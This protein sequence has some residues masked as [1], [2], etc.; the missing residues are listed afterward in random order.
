MV[1][2]ISAPFNPKEFEDI[3][4]SE[5]SIPNI[6]RAATAVN[7]LV[8]EFL[9]GGHR[10]VV[11]STYPDSG[12]M[13]Y[14]QGGNLEVYLVSRFIFLPKREIYSRI[15]VWKRIERIIRLR[16]NELDVLHAHWTYDYAM[17]AQKYSHILPVFCTVRDWCPYQLVIHKNIGSRLYWMVSYYVFKKVMQNSNL[18]LIANSYYTFKMVSDYCINRHIEIIQNP[19]KKDFIL[20]ERISEPLKPTFISIS[21]YIDIRKNIY[22]LLLA[23]KLYKERRPDA[24]LLLVGNDFNYQNENIRTWEK[25]G[26]LSNVKLLGWVNHEDLKSLLDRATALIHPSL[27]ETFGN[28]LLEGMA[29][30]LPVIGGYKSGAV[31]DVLGHGKYGLL[32]D[33]TDPMAIY[34]AMCQIENVEETGKMV[35]L[36]TNYIKETYTSEIIAQKHLDLY[37]SKIKAV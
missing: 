29:R 10:V 33:V 20:S 28:I 24:C 27:E 30:C 9:L 15:Y 4:D 17:A 13:L 36:A 16:V 18:F 1:I 21:Q 2:G 12:K 5:S 6:N 25:E 35:R 26:L 3:L 22:K 37:K 32:C 34:K 7:T 31:P 14:Y 11:F 23:F 8:R 19:I